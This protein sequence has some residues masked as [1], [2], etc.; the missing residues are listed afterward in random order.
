MDKRI[1]VLLAVAMVVSMF[2]VGVVSVGAAEPDWATGYDST[3]TIKA[4]LKYR[5]LFNPGKNGFEGILGPCEV[6][7]SGCSFAPG[8]T[9]DYYGLTP[10]AAINKVTLAYDGA[11]KFTATID[12]DGAAGPFV[13]EYTAA[14]PPGALNYLQLSLR[15]QVV[16]GP[17]NE[18][19]SFN[20]ANL[21]GNPLSDLTGTTGWLDWNLK[22]VDLTS[23]FTLEGDMVLAWP[24]S[25]S[26]CDECNKLVLRV[27]YVPPN[28]PPV[29]N[30]NGPYLGA[31]NSSIAFDGIGSSDPDGDLLTYAWDFGDVN[32]GTGATP[33][34]SYTLADIYNVCLTVNDGTVDSDP[35]CT[36]AVV[37]N[38]EGG[39]VT[40][41][42]WI[43][44]PEGAYAADSALTGKATFGFVSKYK[45]GASVP[46][47]NT[48]FQFKAGDLN[49]HSTSYDWLVVNQGGTNAQ[50]KG[51]GTVNGVGEY[52]F[53]LWATD[54]SPDTFRIRIWGED[55]AGEHVTYDNGV[56]QPIGGGSIV[57]HNK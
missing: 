41:G 45:K 16:P 33:T 13:M 34:H 3:A 23:E 28:E 43:D 31:V 20:N 15:G 39:F 25:N 46:D 22:G 57:V 38:P 18:I 54:G 26:G 56:A 42:G 4:I 36:I 7:V 52:K 27:G 24:L 1:R 21:N 19:V 35:V 2:A 55:S 30:P 47:G 37:Y 29:A 53:M 44:S 8:A 17:V 9:W 11:S 50:F 40:G 6:G 48:E 12:P 49:F 10:Y 51:I 32:T 5:H 14:S